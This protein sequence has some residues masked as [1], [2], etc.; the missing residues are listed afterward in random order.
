MSPDYMEGDFM[1]I[2]KSPCHFR[3]L[4]RGDIIVFDHPS[5]GILLKKIDSILPGGEFLVKGINMKS[6]DSKEIGSIPLSAVH[7]KVVWH[8]HGP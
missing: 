7:G 4:R 5:Y 3:R 8:I 1:L 6:I 2:A